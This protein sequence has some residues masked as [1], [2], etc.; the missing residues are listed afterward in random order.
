MTDNNSLQAS[1]QH[2][3]E[4]EQLARALADAETVIRTYRRRFYPNKSFGSRLYALQVAENETAEIAALAAVR[5]AVRDMDGV[6]A[7]KACAQDGQLCITLLINGT[8]GVVRLPLN[9]NND[10]NHG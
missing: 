6:Y 10:G 3:I 7:L 1:E 8:E 9:E 5:Q 2:Y 4:P